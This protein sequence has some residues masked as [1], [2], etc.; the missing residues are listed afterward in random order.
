ML[1]MDAVLET[2]NPTEFTPW[3]VADPTTD[4]LLALS[5]RLSPREIGTA[6]AVLTSYNK[7]DH[8]AQARDPEDSAEQVS[9]LLTTDQVI[10]PGGIR[11]RD[12]STGTIAPPGCC[13]GLEN[14]RNW[15]DL[16]NGR[17]PWLGHD[18]TPRAELAGETVRLCPD[19]EHP[20]GLPIE[21]PLARIPELLSSVQTQ[22]IAFLT[23]I[24]EWA[25]RYTPL[26]TDALV[27]KL[28]KDLAIKSPLWNNRR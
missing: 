13:F 16:M 28:E 17:I 4:H 11:V 22:L 6:M 2:Y 12:T 3:P 7:S 14:W 1:I 19:S 8:K 9:M 5:G 20:V 23:A 27:A 25:T 26:L 10:A 21:L 15:M 18:P 24:G